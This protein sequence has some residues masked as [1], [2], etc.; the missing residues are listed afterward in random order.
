M[1]E[2]NSNP[3]D[4]VEVSDD[5][6]ALI[7]GTPL[8]DE[9]APS[10]TA[11]TPATEATPSTPAPETALTQA[12]NVPEWFNDVPVEQ[13]AAAAQRIIDALTPEQRN[14]LPAIQQTAQG[15]YQQ[16]AAQ[17]Q[18]QLQGQQQAQYQYQQLAADANEAVD[19][20]KANL[21]PE[22]GLDVDAA[23][24][25][26]K[27]PIQ[28]E[29]HDLMAANIEQGLKGTLGLLGVQ[30]LPD[31]TLAAIAAAP[32]Y[33]SVIRAYGDFFANRGFEL[34]RL[35]ER[36]TATQ[37]TETDKAVLTARYKNWGIAQAVK[38]GRLRIAK[39]AEGMYAELINDTPVPLGN[40]SAS[41]G[42]DDLSQEEF[43]K[44]VAD[45]D[46][47]DQLQSNPAKKAAW[48]RA[49]AGAMSGT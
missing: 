1:S 14:S 35:A 41:G 45:S 22:S 43:E 18:A 42:G 34:G 4:L 26:I 44:A 47:Y 11:V 10:P 29:Y 13:R 24:A 25:T 23:V 30:N 16:T 39:D 6:A 28:A 19:Y 36:N 5:I 38:D 20:I 40:G 8:P 49:I 15:V 33:G 3:T 32:D 46:Y 17:V 9:T 12:D 2:S 27:M 21:H 7:N 37:T 48:D 31:A